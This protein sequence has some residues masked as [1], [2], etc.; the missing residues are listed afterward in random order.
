MVVFPANSYF[1][2]RDKYYG[3]ITQRMILNCPVVVT[4]ESTET[5]S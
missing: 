2:A 5:W 3:V 1:I 4:G